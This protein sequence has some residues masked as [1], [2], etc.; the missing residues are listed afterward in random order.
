MWL[1][2]I[3]LN[4]K[5][6]VYLVSSIHS[7]NDGSFV[8]RLCLNARVISYKTPCNLR[9]SKTSINWRYSNLI[10]VVA[11]E[12]A[13]TQVASL[14][15]ELFKIAQ[16]RMLTTKSHFI[17][18]YRIMFKCEV[19]FLFSFEYIFLFKFLEKKNLK[20]KPANFEAFRYS[21]FLSISFKVGTVAI[22]CQWGY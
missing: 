1:F 18:L 22:F 9:Q 19:L 5:L 7:F 3:I 13:K 16:L 8:T 20:K 17:V 10:I 4:Y 12:K 6:H 15:K 2:K 21:F 11:Y 14:Q